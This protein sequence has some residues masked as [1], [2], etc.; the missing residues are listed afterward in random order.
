MEL[1]L[2]L[3]DL[4]SY[5]SPIIIVIGLIM[6]FYVLKNKD[7]RSSSLLKILAF[8]LGSLLIDIL[9]RLSSKF[10]GSNLFFINIYSL[11]ELIILFYYLKTKKRL[12]PKWYI[13]VF[14]ALIAFNLY[15]LL[16]VDFI[17]FM[18]FQ[19]YSK[20]I[21]SLFLL[22]VTITLILNII[23]FDRDDLM[24]SILFILP[25]YLTINA[26][27]GLPLNLLVNFIDETVYYMWWVNCLNVI[28]FYSVIIFSIWKFGK[29]RKTSFFG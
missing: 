29:T 25:I 11:F 19:S 14:F 27:I 5:I 18:E 20:T 23:R 6:G 15:E 1:L 26:I 21:N 3:I 10:L 8:L 24:N 17:N 2:L 12:F 7:K 28:T 13:F 16:T 4:F 9:S 22:I